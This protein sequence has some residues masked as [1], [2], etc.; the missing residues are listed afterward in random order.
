[1]ESQSVLLQTIFLQ[2][3]KS[4]LHDTTIYRNKKYQFLLFFWQIYIK[5]PVFHPIFP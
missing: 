3:F 5:K 4:A 1:M 2:V